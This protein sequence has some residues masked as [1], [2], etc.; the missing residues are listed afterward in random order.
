RHRDAGP[1]RHRAHQAFEVVR[2]G[3]ARLPVGGGAA[4]QG[5]QLAADQA[6]VDRYGTGCGFGSS[7]NTH[8]PLL[9]SGTKMFPSRTTAPQANS[10]GCW[11]SE[12]STTWSRPNVRLLPPER[13]LYGRAAYTSSPTKTYLPARHA[14]C[15][16]RTKPVPQSC[17]TRA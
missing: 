13:P 14:V 9:M 8:S 4:G 7:F 16:P 12:T 3:A 6:P 5:G 2:R 11:M 1:G 15:V 17:S 10:L